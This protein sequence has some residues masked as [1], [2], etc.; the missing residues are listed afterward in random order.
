MLLKLDLWRAN[1]KTTNME[2]FKHN[3]TDLGNMML[4]NP[5]AK[6]T[7]RIS[8]NG[9]QVVHRF[10][11]PFNGGEPRFVGV[12]W[13]PRPYVLKWLATTSGLVAGK[14]KPPSEEGKLSHKALRQ[15]VC[16]RPGIP[17]MWWDGED[18]PHCQRYA[19][20]FCLYED[21]DAS[22]SALNPT[23]IGVPGTPRPS[24]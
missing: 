18:G 6:G 7:F 3:A 23:G 8:D 24:T 21:A 20:H 2:S 11:G 5:K 17:L 1:Q 14:D 22:G 4:K 15:G 9:R 10:P 12:C 19:L 16:T 13:L